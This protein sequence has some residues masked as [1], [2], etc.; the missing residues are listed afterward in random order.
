MNRWNRDKTV[1]NINVSQKVLSGTALFFSTVRE[2]V[3]S[4]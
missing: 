2:G 4:V 3:S 1:P